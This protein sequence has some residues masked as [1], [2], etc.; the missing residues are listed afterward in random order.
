[1]PKEDLTILLSVDPKIGQKNSQ[2]KN[3]PDI[4]EDNLSHL[5]KTQKIFLDLSRTGK[6]W[7]VIDC[8]KNV[9]MKSPEEIHEEIAEVLSENFPLE[10]KALPA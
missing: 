3:H 1:M 10:K 4:H 5:E 7:V 9:Q 8:M 6:N 2:V